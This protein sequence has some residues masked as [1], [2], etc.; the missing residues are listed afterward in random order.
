MQQKNSFN[1]DELIACGNGELFGPGNPQLPVPNMLMFDAITRITDNEGEYGKGFAEAKLNV[2]PD[3]WFFSC[4]FPGDPVMP[5][6]LGLDALWQLLGFYLGW[7]GG[8]GKGRALGCSEVKFTGQILPENTEVRY[9][10]DVK[11]VIRRRLQMGIADGLVEVDGNVIY[12][13]TDL[14]V[15]LFKNPQGDL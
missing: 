3:L 8:T 7:V 6:C 9:Q 1:Y 14:R 11:R 10:L 2:H 13:A 4:H 5:G 12:R 15:G